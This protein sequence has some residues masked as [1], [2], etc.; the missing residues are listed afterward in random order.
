M[1]LYYLIVYKGQTWKNKTYAVILYDFIEKHW[2]NVTVYNDTDKENASIWL[3][4][5][6]CIIDSV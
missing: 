5:G 6:G 2:E 3:F 1:R 4:F